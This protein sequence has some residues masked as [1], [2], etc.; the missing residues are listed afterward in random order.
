MDAEGNITNTEPF[1]EQNI[2]P[3]RLVLGM[4][5]DGTNYAEA[6][7]LIVDRSQSSFGGYICAA[8]VHMI[9]EAHRDRSFQKIVN[10]SIL[11]TPDGM[12]LKWALH[13]LGLPLPDRVRGP[14]LALDV[15]NLAQQHEVP[16]GLYGGSPEA[17]D[18]LRCQL[19]KKFPALKIVYAFSP[20]FTIPS[21]EE[22]AKDI[23]AISSAGVRILLVGLG[24]PKQEKWMAMASRQMNV[25]MLGVGAFFDL[26]SGR[27]RKC[28]YWVGRIGMEW[29]FRLCLEPKRLFKRY[30]YNNPLFVMLFLFEHLICKRK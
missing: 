16:I 12:P 19:L 30:A 4:R 26:E 10:N 17:L 20:P 18:G 24:C 25:V 6:S 13:V 21:D 9:M 11:V 15:C 8:N 2:I 1:D 14:T 23:A 29:F 22:A 27:I 7:R 3:W 28:P 5:V